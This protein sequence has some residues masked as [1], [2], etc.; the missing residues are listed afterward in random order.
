MSR[1]D[2]PQAHAAIA[3]TYPVETRWGVEI[4]ARDGVVLSANVWLPVAGADDVAGF[5][6]VLEMIPYGKDNW[7]R[8]ADTARGEYLAARGFA[9][10]RLDVRGTG[11]SGGVALDEYTAAE[12]LDGFDAVE[13]LAAQRWCNGSVGMMGISYGGFTAI[14]VAKLRPPHL[15]A[16]VAVQATDDRYRSDVHYVGGCLTASELSQYAV[17]QVAMNAMPPDPAFA[18]PDWQQAWRAR[19]EATPAW[20]FE[21]IRQQVDGPY[22]RQGSLAPD[23]DAI[24]SAMLL[25]GGWMDSYVDA[26]L[27]MQERCTAP[28]RTLIGNWVHGL[29]SQAGPGPNVDELD[30][31]CR[32]FGHW[33]RGDENGVMDEPAI[34]WFER[35]AAEPEP[36]PSMLPGR[37]RAASAYPHPAV[38]PRSWRL[39]SGEVPLVGR[40]I[41]DIEDGPAEDG[42]AHATATSPGIDRYR[43]EP[44]VGTHGPL[45]WGAGGPPNGLSRDIRPD[46]AVGPTFTSDPLPEAV[47]ILGV[48]EVVLHLAA[49]TRTGMVVVRL[50]DVDQ[51]GRSSP[52]TAGILNL[53]HRRS[54]TSPEPL[55]PG[56]VE[57]VRVDLRPAGYRFAAGRRIR[58]SVGASAWP[59]VWPSPE[60]TEYEL[61]HGPATPSRLVLPTIP[62]TGGL[63]D[64][65]PVAMK[66]TP[67]ELRQ[68]GGPGSTDPPE[69]RVVDDVMADTVTVT[70]HDG[71]EDVLEDGR[72]L[73][74]A[75]RLRLTAHRRDPGRTELDADV[76]Y[77]WHEHETDIEIRA[78]SRQVSDAASLDLSVDLAV[79]LDG[80][81]FYERHDR[82]LVPRRLV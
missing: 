22:W 82:E 35:D 1:T 81:R 28:R 31:I 15:R 46:E 17:S 65:E 60:L 34:T 9:L 74:T 30:Q 52:V 44:G 56:H 19:L 18:G 79:D 75:E 67:P 80:Q 37:W 51:K 41:E 66:T 29:P 49:S 4:A 3:P 38:E 68:V 70:T 14:Q 26:A 13:W 24:E 33:L 58:V 48:P 12:T 45:S 10:C 71:A 42:R 61:H 69:W 73:Y 77:R 39:T 54:D 62:S 2:P 63:G 20:L 23:Y 72:R 59:I 27:R 43:H 36:F 6:A 8:N 55:V 50:T 5:P 21:W 64:V 11:S 25:I 16:I 47:S 78:G 7:R 53:T 32:F 76:V 40:L 57:Q